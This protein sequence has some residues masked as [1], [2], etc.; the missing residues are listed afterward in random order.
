VIP[1]ALTQSGDQTRRGD[2]NQ[3]RRGPGE[4]YVEELVKTDGGLREL[5]EDDDLA[6]EALESADRLEDDAVLWLVGHVFRWE[7]LRGAVVVESLVPE[8][9]IA[10]LGYASATKRDAERRPASWRGS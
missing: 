6:L 5:D 10:D 2:D 7:A 1:T 9:D 8:E 4:A 3:L